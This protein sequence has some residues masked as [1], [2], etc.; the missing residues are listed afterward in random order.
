MQGLPA[1]NS[2]TISLNQSGVD[3]D[4]AELLE[5]IFVQLMML[6]CL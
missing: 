5:Y 2:G 6:C 4:V 3:E 1:K